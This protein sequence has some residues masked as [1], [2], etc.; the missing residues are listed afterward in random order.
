[1]T[2]QIDLY[3]SVGLAVLLLLLG[4]WLKSKIYFF[5]KYAIPSPVI[6][7]LLFAF[8]TLFLQS[9][10][11]LSF[12]FDNTLQSFF[13]TIFF[14]SI[15]FNVSLKLLYK[16][17]AKLLL[18]LGLA[19]IFSLFQNIIPIVLANPLGVDARLALMTGSTALMGGLGTSAAIAPQVEE[20]GVTGAHA[21]AIASATFGLLMGSLMGAPI[22][23]NLITRKKLYLNRKTDEEEREI[24][25]LRENS[26]PM[27][28]E[29]ITKASFLILISMGIGVFFTD[30]LNHFMG[31]YIDTV[32]FPVYIGPMI[33]AAIIRNIFD[34]RGNF[35]LN[36]EIQ[37]L[38][39]ICLN[40]FISIA[41]MTLRLW[42]LSELALPLMM[43]LLAQVVLMYLFPRF[44][45]FP[46]LGKDYDAAVSTSGLIGFSMGS[47]ANAMANLDS[48]CDKFGYSRV[49][50]FIVPVVGAFFI[51]FINVLMITGF[52]ATIP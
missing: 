23:N 30:V 47:T 4:K 42:E 31:L 10:H 50:Y 46:V 11:V 21:V 19:T 5:R 13:M 52:L 40:V 44:I 51:D 33:V 35:D 36:P 6:G 29:R 49:A 8:V 18:F 9:V 39:D 26:I 1:M 22:G 43:L 41:I 25:A 15:G 7:G 28:G 3:E 12:Q 37:L 27:N 24:D 32:K 48:I 34:A 45:A 17:G 16:G 38:G 2:L 14:T 20:I